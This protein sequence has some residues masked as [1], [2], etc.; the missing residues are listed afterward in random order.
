M[1]SLTDAPLDHFSSV[2]FTRNKHINENSV[3][4]RYWSVEST[5]S[6]EV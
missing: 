6:S 5:T 3:K 4:I 2:Y 1:D